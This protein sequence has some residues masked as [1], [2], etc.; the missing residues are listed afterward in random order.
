[1]VSTLSHV[2]SAMEARDRH[3]WSAGAPRAT[4]PHREGQRLVLLADV[5]RH[6]GRGRRS[7]PSPGPARRHERP[8]HLDLLEITMTPM[9]RRSQRPRSVRSLGVRTDCVSSPASTRRPTEHRQLLSMTSC[10]RSIG[11]PRRCRS[12]CQLVSLF[13]WLTQPGRPA[14]GCRASAGPWR[15]HVAGGRVRQRCS[16]SAST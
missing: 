11:S 7:P 1:M 9:A 4:T 16:R 15:S 14:T 5:C 6:C 8:A 10:A 12:R 2:R 13:S 3:G